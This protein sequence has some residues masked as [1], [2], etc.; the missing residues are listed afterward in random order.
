MLRKLILA[1]AIAAAA[2]TPA[3]AQPP[4]HDPR[5]D[6]RDAELARSLPGPDDVA[7]AGSRL[8][9][10]VDALM[11]IRIGPLVDAVEPEARRDPNRPETLG[12]VARRRDPY[13]RTKLHV[14]VDRATAGLGTATREVAILAPALR[15]SIEDAVRRVDDAVNGGPPRGW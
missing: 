13:A 9:R 6:P 3:A 11:D 1:A 8:H 5:Y 7:R 12:D 10:L 2:A 15:R 14:G 4:Q